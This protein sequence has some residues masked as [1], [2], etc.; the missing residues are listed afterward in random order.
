MYVNPDGS[1]SGVCSYPGNYGNVRALSGH[2]EGGDWEGSTID[3]Q[4][5]QDA[6]GFFGYGGSPY[7]LG[8]FIALKARSAVPARRPLVPSFASARN[9]Y[10]DRG[11]PVKRRRVAA[12]RQL[13]GYRELPAY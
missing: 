5:D 2:P 6:T 9:I 3:E 4:E 1:L 11:V 10:P 8:A 12:S 7:G 13:S